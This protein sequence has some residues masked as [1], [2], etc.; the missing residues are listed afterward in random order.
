MKRF[1]FGNVSV[2]LFENL[3]KEGKISIKA[4]LDRSYTDKEGKWKSTKSFSQNDLPKA[5][6]ALNK[7]YE[8]LVTPASKESEAIPVEEV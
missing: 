4:S 8:Y 7:A 5:I 3:D 6:L 2:A 1:V